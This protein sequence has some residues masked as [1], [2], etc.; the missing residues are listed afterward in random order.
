MATG[1]GY[2]R[3]AP[4]Q[5][6]LCARCMIIYSSGPLRRVVA[7]VARL[8]KQGRLMIRVYCRRVIVQMTRDTFL[9]RPLVHSVLMALVTI[10]CFMRACKGKDCIRVVIEFGSHPLSF[11][12][13]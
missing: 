7:V 13:T 3:V 6:K 5:R 12:M 8:G 11:R 1:A 2:R 9:R 10:R 4:R